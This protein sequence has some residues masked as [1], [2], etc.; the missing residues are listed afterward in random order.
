M[1][2]KLIFLLSA[3]ILMAYVSKA[4]TTIIVSAADDATSP[5]I[6]KY[7]YSHFAEHLG[8]GIYGGFYVGDTSKIPNTN[9][10]RNDVIAAL[11]EMKIPAL[12]W[13]GRVLC[14]Y[15]S[16]EGWRRPKG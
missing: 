10:V 7:I 6:S 13:P 4:Q 15:L 2:P 14:G 3:F 11:K 9:G 16:L 12:R 1:R 5:K 8:H